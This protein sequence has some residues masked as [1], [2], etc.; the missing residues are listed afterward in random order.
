M[1]RPLAVVGALALALLAH[2]Q[3][4]AFTY[5]GE[6]KSGGQLARIGPTSDAAR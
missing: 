5:Q 2:A 3:S 4:T 1:L 6:V